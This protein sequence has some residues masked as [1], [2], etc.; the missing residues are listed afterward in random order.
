MLTLKILTLV[1]SVTHFW[2][3]FPAILY[4]LKT[5][6]NQRFSGVSRG[7]ETGELAKTGLEITTNVI[8]HQCIGETSPYCLYG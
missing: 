4:P 1:R 7:Y 2:L 3:M 5:R 6:E 8:N